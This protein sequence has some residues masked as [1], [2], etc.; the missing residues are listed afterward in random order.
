M[1]LAQLAAAAT[2]W[3]FAKVPVAYCQLSVTDCNLLFGDTLGDTT[4][5]VVDC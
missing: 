3:S 5:K 2:G 1:G 4:D